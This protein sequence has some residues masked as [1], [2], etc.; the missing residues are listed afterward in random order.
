MV[1]SYGEVLRIESLAFISAEEMEGRWRLEGREEE[2]VPFVTQKN[3]LLKLTKLGLEI[4]QGGGP[5]G[6]QVRA[7]VRK[8]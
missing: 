2:T 7:G 5:G 8:G 3:K 1:V 4:N 6:V